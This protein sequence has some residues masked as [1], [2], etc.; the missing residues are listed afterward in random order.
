MWL[1]ENPHSL[2]KIKSYFAN[3]A[4]CN[5]CKIATCDLHLWPL[6]VIGH[7]LHP[8]P[9]VAGQVACC[10]LNQPSGLQHSQGLTRNARPD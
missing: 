8:D 1:N 5:F 6:V 9:L 10:L 4:L 2:E 7:L 3:Y